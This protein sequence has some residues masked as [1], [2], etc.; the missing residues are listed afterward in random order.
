M[1]PK[2]YYFNTD[3]IILELFFKELEPIQAEINDIWKKE[4]LSSQ[5]FEL[6]SEKK[7]TEK[8]QVDLPARMVN[9]SI[10]GEPTIIYKDIEGFIF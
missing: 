10:A 7:P 5:I 3:D 4:K 9:L 8:I 6:A 2:V 1:K